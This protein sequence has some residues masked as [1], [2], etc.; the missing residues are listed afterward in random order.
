MSKQ[1]DVIRRRRYT[2]VAERLSEGVNDRTARWFRD[3]ETGVW[4]TAESWKRP[5][6]RRSLT[7]EQARYVETLLD[8]K[9]REQDAQRWTDAKARA[10]A[11]AERTIEIDGRLR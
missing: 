7:A 6:F 10:N 3:N 5:N 8:Q 11:W 2:L 1:F 4:Y 9:L